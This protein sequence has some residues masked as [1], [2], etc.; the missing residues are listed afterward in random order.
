MLGFD[1]SNST[2]EAIELSEMTDKN[3]ATDD[4]DSTFDLPFEIQIGEHIATKLYVHGNCFIELRDNSNATLCKILASQSDGRISSLH[5]QVTP[6]YVV[7]RYTGNSRYNGS[8]DMAFQVKIFK[9]G[10]V[11]VLCMGTFTNSASSVAFSKLNQTLTFEYKSGK[12]YVFNPKGDNTYE[13]IEGSVVVLRYKLLLK[14]NGVFKTFNRDINEFEIVFEEG[15]QEL[16]EDVFR[17]HGFIVFNGRKGIESSAPEVYAYSF[18]DDLTLTYTT[19]VVERKWHKVILTEGLDISVNKLKGITTLNETDESSDVR[20]AFSF[21]GNKTWSYFKDGEWNT[22]DISSEE[23]ITENAMSKEQLEEITEESLV[24][25][26]S[27]NICVFMQKYKENAV[28]KCHN[29]RL[30]YS[31]S[32]IQEVTGRG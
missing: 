27:I 17:E 1:I 3:F 22:L 16:S 26:T 18:I 30:E 10:T 15:E 31:E 2:A 9:N 6:H 7:Y 25:F 29:V 23:D 19:E 28:C 14:D 4:G 8:Q 21:D 11:E 5:E 13:K 20:Y 12:S 32:L 24:S